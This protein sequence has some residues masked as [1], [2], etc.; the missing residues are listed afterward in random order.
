MEPFGPSLVAP[1]FRVRLLPA[2]RRCSQVFA[3]VVEELAIHDGMAFRVIVDGIPRPLH[4]VVG[5]EVYRIG[6]EA[7]INAFRHSCAS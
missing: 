2:T 1:S 4:P 3:Q 7:L 6:R 5:D